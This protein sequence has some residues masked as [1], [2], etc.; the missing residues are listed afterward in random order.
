MKILFM[1]TPDFAAVSLEAIIAEGLEVA[2]VITVPD[3]PVGRHHTLTPS[4]VKK[5]AISHNIPVYQPETLRGEGFDALLRSV[6]PEMIVLVAYGKLLPENVLN[7]PRYGCVNLHGSLLP[8][9]RGAAPM[10][11]A[12][13]AGEREIGVTTMFMEKGLDTGPI[14]EKASVELLS[15]EDFEWVHDTLAR[16]GAELLISTITKIELGCIT[17][18]PQDE[19]LATYAAKIEKEDCLL[20]F[21]KSADEL[22]DIIRALSP[23]PLAFTRL[24]GRMLKIISSKV[25]LETNQNRGVPG[26]VLS[27]DEGIIEV[28]C[29]SSILGIKEVLPEGKSR[30]S[31]SEFIRGRGIEKGDILS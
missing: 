23:A 4:A 25:L 13:M 17:A 9:Y 5:A 18:V 10:Q 2:A 30:M 7:Y 6:D 21:T 20:D 27:T 22:H 14:L 24:K 19:L 16:T 3:K 28:E 15:D 1:G 11:R 8:R 29:G 26:T 31:A 12:V